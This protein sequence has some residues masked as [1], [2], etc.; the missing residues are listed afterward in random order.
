VKI[1]KVFAVIYFL[2]PSY[3]KN[4]TKCTLILELVFTSVSD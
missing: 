4:K 1:V 2:M 3:V